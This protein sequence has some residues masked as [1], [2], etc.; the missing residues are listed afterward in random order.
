MKINT[1]SF[2]HKGGMENNSDWAYQSISEKNSV[3]L[4]ADGLDRFSEEIFAAKTAVQAIMENLNLSE[5]ILP[6]T[7]DALYNGANNAILALNG[8]RA[9]LVSVFIQDDLLQYANI[10]TTRFFFFKNGSLKKRTI[11]QCIGGEKLPGSEQNSENELEPDDTM[12]TEPHFVPDSRRLLCTLGSDITSDVT[13]YPSIKLAAGDAFL[14]CTD[15]FW[16][17]VFPVEMMIDLHKSTTPK[18][19]VDFM[20]VRHMNRTFTRERDS[21]S[22]IAGFVES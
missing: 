20:L 8:P 7:I 6:E 17:Q 14:L 13:Q 3:L 22:V 4:L 5:R 12:D 10:G 15:G 1:I 19:W 16:E 21:L 18:A 2:S 9:A 11:D